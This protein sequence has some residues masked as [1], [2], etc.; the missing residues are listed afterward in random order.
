MS[1]R[2]RRSCGPRPSRA[3]CSCTAARK[4]S[5]P[6]ASRSCS[7]AT[8][9]STTSTPRSRCPTTRRTRGYTLLCRAHVYEDV[10][11]ELLNY[12]EE[13]IRS[14]L[15]IQQAV[16]EVVSNDP[17]THDMRHLVLRLIEPAEVKFFPRPVHGTSRSPAPTR[18]ARSRWPTPRAGTGDARV[19][20]QGVPRRPLLPIPRRAAHGRR[21]PRRDRPVRGLHPARRRHR[22]ALR[23]RRRGHGPDPVPPPHDGRARH[24]PQGHVLL[25]RPRRARDLCFT[26]E[27]AA[28]A[29]KLPNFTYIP[30]LSDEGLVGR[31]RPH[32]RC[33]QAARHQRG[34][35]R[36]RTCADRPRWSRRRSPC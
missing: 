5:A 36:T 13:M 23:R 28:I 20:H 10:T 1:P 21:P 11:I 29:E 12:D 22:A 16:A 15:P 8:T 19:R 32:H 27:L 3:S 18:S 14:G 33:R 4:A 25:R 9:S 2:T 6:P 30:A 17:V 35:E 34:A 24:R 31:D 7:R 26:E